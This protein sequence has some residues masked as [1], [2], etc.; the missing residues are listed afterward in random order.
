[1]GISERVHAQKVDCLWHLHI[2]VPI[3]GT[4]VLTRLMYGNLL[5]ANKED[6]DKVC[7]CE[8][9]NAQASIEL[10][11]IKNLSLIHI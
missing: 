2:S 3:I 7:G 4:Q 6:W 1:M 10:R 5:S 11:A 9:C 8:F